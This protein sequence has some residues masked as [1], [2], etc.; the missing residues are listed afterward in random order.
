MNAQIV[1][2]NA[3]EE[4]ATSNTQLDGALHYREDDEEQTDEEEHDGNPNPDLKERI[5]VAGYLV[6][7]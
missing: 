2:R 7:G 6:L 1:D 5:N 3:S 4:D